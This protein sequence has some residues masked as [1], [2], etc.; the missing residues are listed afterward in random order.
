MDKIQIHPT[1]WVDPSDRTNP[2]KVLAAELLRGVGGLLLNKRGERFCDELGTRAYIT[3]A[4]FASEN[5]HYAKT[6]RWDPESQ[7]PTFYLVLSASAAQEGDKHVTIYTHKGL[8]KKFEGVNTL[9]QWMG[10]PEKNILSTLDKYRDDAKRGKDEFGKTTFRNIPRDDL[11]AE[12]FYVGE[13]IPVLH[14]CMGG[15]AIDT[16]G[17]VLNESGEIIPGLY[18]AGEVTGGVHGDNRLGGNSL[19]E[20]AVFG[21]VLGE[22]IRVKDEKLRKPSYRT[23]VR[24]DDNGPSDKRNDL[25]VITAVEL[26]RHNVAN[27]CWVAVRDRVYDLTKFAPDHPGKAAPIHDLAGKDASSIFEAIH[28]DNIIARMQQYV[29]GTWKAPPSTGENASLNHKP[30]E[31]ELHPVSLEELQGHSTETDCW[32]VIHGT[33]FDL[34]EFSSVHP[35]GSY[36]ITKFAGKDATDAFQGFHPADKLKLASSFAVGPFTTSPKARIL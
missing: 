19:L 9:A 18:A 24:G 1:G 2:N 30:P 11:F 36:L 13:V 12:T 27:D 21:S 3:D 33:V 34:T 22:R 17:N 20:C 4:M 15:L 8:M 23:E 35:G 7:V 28:G 5:S 29:V 16:E 14:Y 32:V 31:K 25:A 10:A 6:R 26:A